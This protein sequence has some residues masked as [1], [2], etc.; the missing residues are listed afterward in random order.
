M[1]RNLISYIFIYTLLCGC[2][3]SG[4]PLTPEVDSSFLNVYSENNLDENGYYHLEYSGYNYDK[5]FYHTSPQERVFWGSVDDFDVEWMGEIFTTPIINFSTYANNDGEGQQ[6]FFIDQTMIGD[7]LQIV[8][9]VDSYVWDEILII[10]G[11]NNG[12]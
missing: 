7:T 8:G 1:I 2:S 3:E 5:V 9:W 4:N 11:E 12:R 10:V 6:M